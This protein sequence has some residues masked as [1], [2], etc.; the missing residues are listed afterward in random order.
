MKVGLCDGGG[1]LDPSNEIGLFEGLRLRLLRG[2]LLTDLRFSKKA[3]SARG[4]WVKGMKIGVFEG[5]EIRL[6]K[7]G[8]FEGLRLFSNTQLSNCAAV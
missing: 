7:V 2:S 8:L 3:A 4:L 1:A 5:L 6:L